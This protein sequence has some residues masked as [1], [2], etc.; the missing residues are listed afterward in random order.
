MFQAGDSVME[1]RRFD[2]ADT[3]APD[4]VSVN[5]PSCLQSQVKHSR[6]KVEKTRRIAERR[7]HLE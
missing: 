5:I 2:V 4:G 1:D 6:G 7:I 3:L